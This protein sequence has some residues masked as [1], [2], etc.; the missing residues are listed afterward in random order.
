[1]ALSLKSGKLGPVDM[2][3][4]TLESMLHAEP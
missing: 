3:L 4:P 2:F 1:V